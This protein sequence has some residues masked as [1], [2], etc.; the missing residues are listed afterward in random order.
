MIRTSP[1]PLIPVRRANPKLVGFLLHPISRSETW[2]RLMFL[3]VR[4]PELL[5]RSSLSGSPVPGGDWEGELKPIDNPRIVLE[6]GLFLKQL[7][8]ERFYI[9]CLFPAVYGFNLRAKT[10]GRSLVSEVLMG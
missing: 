10:C 6:P 4:A 2:R 7:K 1:H 8:W 9:S 5:A 3:Q